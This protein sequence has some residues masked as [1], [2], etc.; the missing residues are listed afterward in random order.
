MFSTVK[1]N[2]I[3]VTEITEPIINVIVSEFSEPY[4][5]LTTDSVGENIQDKGSSKNC[6]SF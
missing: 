3:K 6:H 4:I 1:Y 5:S 2:S